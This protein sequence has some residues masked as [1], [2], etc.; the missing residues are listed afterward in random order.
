[1]GCRSK[2]EGDTKVLVQESERLEL[3]R[4]TEMGK[5]WGSLEAGDDQTNGEVPTRYPRGDIHQEAGYMNLES[6]RFCQQC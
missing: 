6:R 2:Y 3:A 5:T 4:V 1:M